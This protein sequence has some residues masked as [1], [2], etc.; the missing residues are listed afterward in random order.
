MDESGLI[1]DEYKAYLNF[2]GEPGVGDVFLKWVNDVQWDETM[3]RRE[4]ITP[5]TGRTFE[6][7]PA[8]PKLAAFDR[9]DRKYAA[10]AK[11]CGNQAAV[12]NAAD[13]DWKHYEAPFARN[14]VKVVNLCPGDLKD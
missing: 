13:S 12:Y 6:E 10:L 8:D 9:S 4:R 5:H 7:Y 1:F 3:C 14:G 11:K 2:E